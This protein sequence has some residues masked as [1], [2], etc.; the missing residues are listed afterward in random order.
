MNLHN[1]KN[2]FEKIDPAIKVQNISSVSGGSINSA[3][4]VATTGED[5]FIK[6]NTA[7]K[8]PKMFA[9]EAQ[10]LEQLK[11][12]G[13]VL[14][15]EII[16]FGEEENW[17]YLVL[18]WEE[19]KNDNHELQK[20]LGVSLAQM[21]KATRNYF[22]WETNNFIGSLEQ[23]NDKTENWVEFFITMRLE[24][25]LKLARD[26]GLIYPSL[27]SKMKRLFTGLETWVPQEKPALLHGDLWG[28]NYLP[29]V[30]G[31]MLIDPAVYFGHREMDLAMM[32]LFG[33]F[34]ETVFQAYHENFP[35]ESGW[36]DRIELHNLYPVL[37]H[38]NL[39]GAGYLGQLEAAINK[40]V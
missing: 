5:Y 11:N 14:T 22:G 39:F 24:P 8:Y 28:G 20:S 31:P 27:T 12:E 13:G 4:K 3:L 15:P 18:S 2:I 1:I 36:K 40:Y 37:V 38:V 10:G 25:Q 34:S 21:H 32:H 30:K 16:D 23:Q 6:Y 9:L 7:K 33:G 19:R 26:T 29:S 17:S 35:L